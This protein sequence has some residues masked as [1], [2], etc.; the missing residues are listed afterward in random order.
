MYPIRQQG[1][2]SITRRGGSAWSSKLCT[3]MRGHLSVV[4]DNAVYPGSGWSS[5]RLQQALEAVT[6]FV[7]H[8]RQP[9]SQ[10]YTRNTVYR[11]PPY[12]QIFPIEVFETVVD[13]ASDHYRSLRNIS[14]TCRT[15]LPR[16]RY[17]LFYTIV[18]TS[19][20]RMLSV[21]VFLQE[22][23]WLFP[24]VRVIRLIASTN[25]RYPYGW[26]EVVPVPLLTQFPNLS[27]FDL[28]SSIYPGS[29]ML[30]PSRRTLSALCVYSAPIQHLE[31][32]GVTF[33]CIDDL[34]RYVSAFTNLSH[35]VYQF[36]QTAR[37]RVPLGVT[38]TTT[39]N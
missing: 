30:S 21:P 8:S 3:S 29:S 31:L 9:N 22:R 11:M 1:P 10:P 20:E 12:H 38:T 15:F 13:Q 6:L 32:S 23:P 16:A 35:L 36:S 18:I 33:L 17:H 14:L 5:Y 39:S 34:M 24:L 37:Y 4:A 19:K 25:Q 2:E 7:V 28:R 27:R 26:L